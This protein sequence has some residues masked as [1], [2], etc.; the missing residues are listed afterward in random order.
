MTRIGGG[1]APA[2]AASRA[3]HDGHARRPDGTGAPQSAQSMVLM[4]IAFLA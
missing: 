4:V 3:P 2:T 1:G